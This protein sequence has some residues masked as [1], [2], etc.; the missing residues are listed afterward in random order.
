MSGMEI[1]VITMALVA[2]G[3]MVFYLWYDIHK[4]GW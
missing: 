1:L 3:G 2:L 4:N